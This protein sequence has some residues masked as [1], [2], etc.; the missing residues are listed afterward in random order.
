MKLSVFV[1]FCPL[2]S[3]SVGFCLFPQ[4]FVGF[5]SNLCLKLSQILLHFPKHD[6]FCPK[7]DLIGPKYIT[8]IVLN[9]NGFDFFFNHMG[10]TGT[11]RSPCLVSFCGV[12]VRSS[13]SKRKFF[14]GKN[15]LIVRTN[16]GIL[17]IAQPQSKGSL[18]NITGVK[19]RPRKNKT[20]ENEMASQCSVVSY[21]CY[22]SEVYPVPKSCEKLNCFH[23]LFGLLAFQ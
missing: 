7:Y 13:L 10:T 21:L 12:C 17:L 9:M 3:I 11:T 6:L 15:P 14:Y 22:M 18:V 23:C 19:L 4:V 1:F 8:E 16:Q 20:L 2:F 5:S